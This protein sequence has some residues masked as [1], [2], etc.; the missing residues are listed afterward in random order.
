MKPV[1]ASSSNILDT[2][3]I[4][5]GWE[6]ARRKDR[7]PVLS[8]DLLETFGG[9][10]ATYRLG[11]PGRVRH[12]EI[13]TNHFKGNFPHSFSLEGMLVRNPF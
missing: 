7:P 9:E 2:K 12:V 4:I 5:S 10:W 13:D 11:H 3:S 6:S 8:T 1:S